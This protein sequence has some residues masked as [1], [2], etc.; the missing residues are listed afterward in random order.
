MKKK[1]ISALLAVTVFATWY[2]CNSAKAP[3][4][5][6]V[7][8]W[9]ATSAEKLMRDVDYSARYSS[10]T[11]TIDA[12]KNEYESAQ[13]LISSDGEYKYDVTAADLKNANGDVL[14]ANAFTLYH[15]KYVNVTK[16]RD[17]NSPTS[18]GYYSDAL[19]PLDKAIEYGENVITGKNQGVWVT[20]NVP[21]TQAAGVYTGEF[22]VTVNGK[23]QAVPVRVNV[24]DYMLSDEVH[25]K[26]SFSVGYE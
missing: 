21:K 17:E 24:Y 22:T 4:E 13:I 10:K 3:P 12:F 16:I 5:Y 25:S 18:V 2:G 20:L 11:L 8:V 19:V 9:T 15:E 7:N 6:A 23:T 1:I 14:S 26:S